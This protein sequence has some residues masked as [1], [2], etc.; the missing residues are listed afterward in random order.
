MQVTNYNYTQFMK[1]G[2]ITLISPEQIQQV[3]N[4][5]EAKYPQEAK[6]LICALYV[7]GARPIEILRLKAKDVVKEASYFK[8]TLSG[9][10]RGL[11]RALLIPQR[12][13][14]A[15][16]IY[17]YCQSIHPELYA[18]ADYQSKRTRVK[19]TKKGESRTY[20]V[21][22]DNLTYHFKR[23]F[24]VLNEH[25]YPPYFL[26]HN[27]FS[28]LSANGASDSEIQLAKGSRTLASVQPYKHLSQASMKKLAR[29]I[30]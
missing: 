11:P 1:E 22:S 2:I 30:K 21:L 20:A 5:I 27:R 28:S 9:S 25:S 14:F 26:R 3:L 7:T 18:F 4:N 16:L 8:I 15:K 29:L 23:W 24:K 17:N 6:A 13:P 12:N 19:V 10:K